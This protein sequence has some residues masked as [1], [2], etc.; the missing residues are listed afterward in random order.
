PLRSGPTSG[1]PVFFVH[2]VVGL[3]W[4]FSRLAEFVDADRPVYG[5]QSPALS[6]TEELPG[7]VREW[8]ALYV[9][10]IRRAHPGGP[11]HLV[12]WSMGGVIAHEMAVQL[13]RRGSAV[14]SLVLLDA[15]VP[16][17]LPESVDP[18][19]VALAA[20]NGLDNG[21]RAMANVGDITSIL[22]RVECGG[23][24]FPSVESLLA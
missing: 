1:E 18:Q 22:G 9:D 21:D 5:L 7:S 3:A 6:G 13:Q 12:G 2:P 15:H 20:L 19:S 8:A 14:G 23:D 4:G 17:P 16:A 10:E 24:A 11:Y